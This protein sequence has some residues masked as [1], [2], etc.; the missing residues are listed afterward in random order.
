MK[1]PF[2]L[3]PPLMSYNYCYDS[4]TI[5]CRCL[6]SVRSMF[7]M[8]PCFRLA[9]SGIKLI[10]FPEERKRAFFSRWIRDVW[11]FSI[12]LRSHDLDCFICIDHFFTI[13]HSQSYEIEICIVINLCSC[14]LHHA[15]SA[16]WKVQFDQGPNQEK[17]NHLLVFLCNCITFY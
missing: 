16:I 15:T 12:C 13:I 17:I 11:L 1:V 2:L 6:R 10:K 3:I 8:H 5:K 9:R 4:T 14:L 7:T